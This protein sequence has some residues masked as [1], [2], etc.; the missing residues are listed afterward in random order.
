MS[1][2]HS[3]CFAVLLAGAA[4]GASAQSFEADVAPLVEASC[5]T[6]H[7]ARTTTP[8]DI[9][10]LG[11]DLGDR[12]TFRAWE[13][14][15]DRVA[16]GEM[17]PPGVRRPD[18]AMVETALG[19]LKR[20]LVDANLAA[21]NGPRTPLRRLTRLEYAHTI[22]DLLHV[23][24]EVGLD[25]SLTLPAEADSGGFDTVAA[26]Q[27]MSPL[28]V[29][30]YLEAADRALDAAIRTGPRP[31]PVHHNVSHAFKDGC[32][33]FLPSCPECWCAVRRRTRP[34]RR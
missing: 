20:A 33:T 29:R 11:H 21:R 28:H 17:P 12:A 18:P 5:L 25:L 32:H 3:V 14:I 34:V 24:E 22:Q 23:D 13:R 31:E 16:S 4:S 6:C 2:T 9:S 1:R 7:G 26:N 15:H 19:S 27:S 10:G 8:L 30:S